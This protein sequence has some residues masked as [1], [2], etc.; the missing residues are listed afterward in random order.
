MRRRDREREVAAGRANREWQWRRREVARRTRRYSRRRPRLWFG[1]GHC[2]TARPPLLS[3]I[4]RPQG[5]H[6]MSHRKS[7]ERPDDTARDPPSRILTAIDATCGGLLFATLGMVVRLDHGADWTT[8]YVVKYHLLPAA[9]GIIVGA[10]IGWAL[11]IA[12]AGQGLSRAKRM[13]G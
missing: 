9:V 1:G 7:G 3:W 5:V 6:P 4:V 2:L 13:V 12:R 10:A 11:A 8:E